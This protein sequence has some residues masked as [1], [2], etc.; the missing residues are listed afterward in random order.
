MMIKSWKAG[1]TVRP[2]RTVLLRGYPAI[3]RE[4]GLQAGSLLHEY[5][6]MFIC[7]K[8]LKDSIMI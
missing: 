4:A 7:I 2:T 1:R 8:E 3:E 5:I 6:C